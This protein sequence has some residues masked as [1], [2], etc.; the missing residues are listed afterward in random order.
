V[1]PADV[2]VI[3]YAQ[4][5]DRL[6]IWVI[7]PSGIEPLVLPVPSGTL[8]A[9]VNQYRRALEQ[10]QPD[11]RL[12]ELSSALF[13]QILRPVHARLRTYSTLVVIPD[14]S[15]HGVPFAALFDAERRRYEIE[16]HTVIVS[17]AFTHFAAAVTSTFDWRDSHALRAIVVTNPKTTGLISEQLPPL[18][19]AEAEAAQMARLFGDVRILRDGEATKSRLREALPGGRILHVASHARVNHR[20]PWRSY[21][22]LAPDGGR[23]GEDLLLMSE[24]STLPLAG[25]RLAVLAACGSADG[26]VALGG[27]SLSLARPFLSAGVPDV[28][29]S[30][31]PVSDRAARAVFTDFYSHVVQGT[32]PATAL[33]EAQLAMLRSSTN[34]LQSPTFWAPFVAI[35]G[36]TASGADRSSLSTHSTLSEVRHESR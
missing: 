35:G 17:P 10:G 27:A 34:G 2:A 26:P 9:R 13:D 25:L 21:F 36:T 16:D 23:P 14:D 7:T 11:A 32:P 3:Y 30:L 8:R 1:L 4:L 24:I 15:L 33:R 18:P 19:G 28:V 6:A 5:A 22:V 31:W 12:T 29:A 20:T